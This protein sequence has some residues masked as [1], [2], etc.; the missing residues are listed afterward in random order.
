MYGKSIHEIEMTHDWS[1]HESWVDEAGFV[2]TIERCREC[3]VMRRNLNLDSG[4]ETP[5]TFHQRIYT[6]PF[7]HDQ[8]LSFGIS[9]LLHR[10]SAIYLGHGL[11][12]LDVFVRWI[13]NKSQGL[14][15]PVAICRFSRCL[16]GPSP[17]S[18]CPA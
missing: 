11:P 18:T 3:G 14:G 9:K 5:R 17:T 1:N 12:N 4:P 16:L 6:M 2:T 7:W 13:G 15:F 8:L 10:V